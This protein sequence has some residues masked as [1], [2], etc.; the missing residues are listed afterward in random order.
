MGSLHTLKIVQR[1][2]VVL[3]VVL[4]LRESA[5]GSENECHFGLGGV[6]LSS[7][8]SESGSET[9]TC[10]RIPCNITTESASDWVWS[11]LQF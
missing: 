1:G 9:A 6:H 5:A 8:E 2:R 7:C 3:E 4:P 11:E 10:R